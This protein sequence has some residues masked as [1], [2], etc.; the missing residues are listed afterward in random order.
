MKKIISLLLSIVMIFT[1][2]IS[3]FAASNETVADQKQNKTTIQLAAGNY[4]EIITEMNN[5]TRVFNDE[6]FFISEYINNELT[7]TVEGTFGG[8]QLLCT[9]YKGGQAVSQKIINV[10]DRVSVSDSSSG[11]KVASASY[12]SVLGKIVYNKD[13]GNNTPGEEITVYS[14]VTD[15]DNEAYTIHGAVTDRISL[16]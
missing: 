13:I 10:A 4:M 11:Q 12:G 1:M 14:K 2:S 6:G 15:Q 7:H 9:D 5:H 8:S 16:N 3:T